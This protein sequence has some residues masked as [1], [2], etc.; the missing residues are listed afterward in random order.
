MSAKKTIKQKFNVIISILFLVTTTIF[1]SAAFAKTVITIGTTSATKS[2]N[3]FV[4]YSVAYYGAFRM[5]YDTL[6]IPASDGKTANSIAVDT[7]RSTDGLTYTVKIRKDAMFQDGKPLTAEDVAFS[8]NY[9]ITNEIGT[10]TQYTAPVK[11]VKVIDAYTV[12]FKLKEAINSGWLD[13]NTF[14]WVPML[15]KHIWSKISKKDALGKLSVDKLIGSGPFYL[16][17]FEADH[18]MRLTVTESGRRL[19]N[20]AF[21][22]VIIKQYANDSAML[23]DF[24]V[25]NIHIVPGLPEKS[26]PMIKNMK[27]VVVKMFPAYWFDEVIINSWKHAYKENRKKHPHPAL[28][29]LE[30]RKALDWTLNEKLAAKV[31]HGNYSI[32]GAAHMLPTGYGKYCNTDLP[33]RGYDIEKAKKILAAAG[34]KDTD[35]DGIL[36]TKDGLALDFD[37][38]IPSSKTHEVDVATIWAREAKKVGIKMNISAMDGDTLWAKMSPSGGYDIALWNW[39]GYADPDYLL[40]VLTSANAVDGGWSDSGF[41]NPE[42]DKLY[43]QQRVAKTLEDRYKI[44]WKMQEILYNEMPY[45]VFNYWGDIGAINTARASGNIALSE[46][47]DGMWTRDFVLSLKPL[48]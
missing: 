41:Q 18:F 37:V 38:W 11:V 1:G 4:E 3:P 35:D 47:N 42:F 8:Y 22:E 34:Y 19:F 31:A 46:T 23:Q 36:E 43:K 44:V 39:G 9:I 28:K 20:P 15:P 29:D 32:P 16:S 27:D 45:L 26:V 13:Q 6:Q 25:G 5:T 10:Y 30:I 7:K 14:L 21:D 2:S 40:S 17:E 24:K 33:L 48:K 12:A